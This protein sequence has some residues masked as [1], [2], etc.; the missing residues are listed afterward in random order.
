MILDAF[1]N[2][3]VLGSKDAFLILTIGWHQP[4]RLGNN[5]GCR[6][7]QLPSRGVGKCWGVW[8]VSRSGV[9]EGAA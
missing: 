5:R 4:I 6:A 7:A 9:G 8:G 3:S 1:Q 2:L